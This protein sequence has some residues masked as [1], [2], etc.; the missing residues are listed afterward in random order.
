MRLM[1]RFL[2]VA[3]AVCLALAAAPTAA[4]QPVLQPPAQ[5]PKAPWPNRANDVMPDWLRVRGEFRGRVEG[6]DN[7]GFD[8]ARDD[9][10][11][12]SRIR[13]GA[14][15]T[16]RY[17]AGTVQVQDARVGGK[18]V[19]ATGTPFSAPFDLRQA[20]VDIGTAKTPVAVRVGR[21][22]LTLGD[23]RLVGIANWTN[24]ARTFD[25]GHVTFRS[26]PV[27]VD[28]FAASVVRILDGE[29]DKSGHGNRLAGV[30]VTVPAIVPKGTLDGY[31]L[32]HRDVNLLSESKAVGTLSQFTS[33]IRLVGA[34]PK[35]FDYNVE[36]NVQSGTLAADTVR[37][38]AGH[39]QVRRTIGGREAPHI[40]GEF[41]AASGDHDP[42]DG[43]RGTFDQL[44]PT[45]HD[46]YG[47]ADQVGWRNIRHVRLGGDL[48]PLKATPIT[49]NYHAYWLAERRDG[50]YTSGGSL[51]ARVP[52]GAASRRVG[53][54]LDVQMVRPLTAQI[55]LAAGY[56]HL[57]AGPFLKEATPGRS[58]SGAFAMLTYVLLADR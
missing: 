27:Q 46:R 45:S 20:Y 1:G 34:L 9:L 49:V 52:A 23:Q 14:T 54:E 44:Y 21:Q 5:Q 18:T 41:N 24:A 37:A 53:Q 33:G 4:Q 55:S 19:G 17:L 7:A 16:S 56:T 3:T 57:F 50:L 29:F 51:L 28:V 30:D 39:W 8:D 47:L 6:F 38:W 15:A 11:S 48:S 35:A 12:L 13:L 58:Y 31:V 25:A 36:M 2:V 10:Y 40:I 32:W 26:A 43:T 42:G 22:E